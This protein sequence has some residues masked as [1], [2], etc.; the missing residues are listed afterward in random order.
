MEHG[1]PQHEVERAVLEGQGLGVGDVRLDLEPQ[2]LGVPAQ[3]VDHARRDVGA[4]RLARDAGHQQVQREVAGSGADL[5]RALEQRQPPAERL[6]DLAEH[7]LAA[8]LA[9]VDAPL[10]VVVRGRAVVVTGVDVADRVGRAG[11]SHQ[12][13]E[14]NRNSASRERSPARATIARPMPDMLDLPP[15]PRQPPLAQFLQWVARPRE[16][17][18]TAARAL[19]RR[20]HAELRRRAVRL[21]RRSRGRAHDLHR[22]RGGHARRRCQRAA[23]AGRRPRLDPAARRG[24]PSSRA[25]DDAARLPR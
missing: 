24:R 17:A 21:P 7:L 11:R 8:D 14:G 4:R 10:G 3:H 13:L 18:G 1:V 25:P 12:A 23:R 22:R 15:G 2:A 5:E 20:L 16:F 6:A 9:P 19:R